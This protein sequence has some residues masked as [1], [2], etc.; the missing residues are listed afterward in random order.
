MRKVMWR[1]NDWSETSFEVKCTSIMLLTLVFCI[2]VLTGFDNLK[3]KA[4]NGK[5]H[6]EKLKVTQILS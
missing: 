1:C 3:G 2:P 5:F 6:K 4:K